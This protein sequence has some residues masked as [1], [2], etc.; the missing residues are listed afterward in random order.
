M[1]KC[2]GPTSARRRVFG[3]ND[4]TILFV[5][6]GQT[7]WNAIGRMQGQQNSDLDARG[8][9]QAEVHGRLLAA[10]GVDTLVA[11]PLERARQTV[12]I[13]RRFVELEPAFDSR[14]VEWDC[15]VWSGELRAEVKRR[16]P[17]EWAALEADPYHS[18]GPGCENYP[19]M[20]V[21]VRPFV[22]ELVAGAGRRIA[23][24]SHGMI[25]R[26]MVGLLM[27][28]DEPAMLAFRQP[29]QVIYRVRLGD[30]GVAPRLDRFVGGLGPFDGCVP[31]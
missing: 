22:D 28:F 9:R 26:V 18:R 11:S 17:E 23:V 19:D 15:G 20:S 31:R 3:I 8:R 24:V 7:E 1:P 2:P 30:S 6:H 14:I 5:R 12:A 27:G 4:K 25:G 29:N 21:R 10:V 16:W 13:V